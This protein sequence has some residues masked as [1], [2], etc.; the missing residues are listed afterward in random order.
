MHARSDTFEEHLKHLE[1]LFKRA[2]K[3]NISF[4]FAK[5]IFCH[6]HI[7][8]WGYILTPDGMIPD[9]EKYFNKMSPRWRKMRCLRR[10]SPNIN[11]RC[12]PNIVNSTVIC[13]LCN[14]VYHKSD[15][16]RILEKKTNIARYVTNVLVVCDEH[17]FDVTS[18]KDTTYE[19]FHSALQARCASAKSYCFQLVFEG[20]RCI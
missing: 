7:E 8:F 10:Q 14:N 9:P 12:Q 2:S 16:F 11:C 1:L 3:H 17:D 5:T 6:K 13:I 15:F 19:A 4:N 18:N 20:L